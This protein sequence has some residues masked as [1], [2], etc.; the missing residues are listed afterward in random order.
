[1]L[2]RTALLAGLLWLPACSDGPST[3]EPQA[4]QSSDGWQRQQVGTSVAAL[5]ASLQGMQASGLHEQLL[6]AVEALRAAP[7]KQWK[8]LDGW[9][10]R[11]AE[12]NY[13]HKW[14]T[15]DAETGAS[16]KA[17]DFA[18]KTHPVHA[19]AAIA[20]DL[21]AHGIE[22]LVIPIPKRAQVYP[23]RLPGVEQAGSDFAGIDPGYA[24]VMLELA[25]RGVSIVDL[26]PDMARTRYDRSGTDDE[27]LFH[28]YDPHWTPRGAEIAADLIASAIASYP[29]FEAGAA[30]EGEDFQVERKHGEWAFVVDKELQEEKQP[31]LLWF[32]QMRKPDGGKVETEARDSPYLLL[33]DSFTTHLAAAGS[34]IVSLLYA[35]LEQ[36]LDVIAI[37]QGGA[38]PVWD[39]LA[40]R[41]DK[42]EGKRVV[43]WLVSASV[44][45]NQ[46]LQKVELFGG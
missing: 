37:P 33:G 16:M 14:C 9:A 3:P 25:R 5:E 12:L 42:L 10:I 44:F 26:L 20:D 29:W 39:A 11:S 23:D 36:P 46:N 19:I 31:E 2:S 15:P 1:M 43:I 13:Y 30:V 6:T 45:A 35:R 24:A 8:K 7:G 18:A 32:R 38:R 41:R 22:L 21:E 4:Q 17:L 28:H 34:D 27:Y 40:R